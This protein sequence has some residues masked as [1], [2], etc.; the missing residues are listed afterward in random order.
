MGCLV[1]PLPQHPATRRPPGIN[2]MM[3]PELFF[4][5]TVCRRPKTGGTNVWEN[6]N[7]DGQFGREMFL[8]GSPHIML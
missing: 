6:L 4:C 2:S 8:H 1:A 3:F 5:V 7:I